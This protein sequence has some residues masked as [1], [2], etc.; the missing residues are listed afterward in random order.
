[1]GCCE[2][3]N[4]HLGL[5]NEGNS[6]MSWRNIS[7]LRRTPHPRRQSLA[8]CSNKQFHHTQPIVLPY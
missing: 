3:G 5:Q 1:M 7:Y 6:L 2:H 8:Y 4:V